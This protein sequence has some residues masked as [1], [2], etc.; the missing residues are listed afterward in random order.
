MS[1]NIAA[2]K[3]VNARRWAAMHVNPA[4]IPALDRVA[5][6]L[7]AP[8]AMA[9]YQA[10]SASTKVP[11]WVIAVI[12]ERESSQNWKDSLAQGDP[13]N[14]VSTHVP[15]GRGPFTSWEQAAVDA[16]ENAAPYAAR[17]TDWSAGGTLTLLEEYNGLGYAKRG[18][19]SPY[20]WASTN[21]YVK[22]KYVADGRFDPNAV[23]RQQGCAALLARMAIK[24][25]S[26]MLFTPV[27]ATNNPH[28]PVAAPVAPTPVVK[29]PVRFQGFCIRGLLSVFLSRAMENL[30]AEIN[31]RYPG[32]MQV[33]DHGYW[34]SYFSNV[35]WLTQQARSIHLNNKRVVLIG[36]SFGA[37]AAIMAANSLNMQD[38]PVD[39]LCPIDPAAQYSTAVPPNVKRVVAFY[40]TTPGDLGE[41]V[42]HA[43]P[44]WV[45][46]NWTARSVEYHRV[47]GHLAIANDPFVHA[48]ILEAI[49]ELT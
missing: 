14:R 29:T 7:V 35:G 25:P 47:E 46:A 49:K 8:V 36:H 21:Q 32:T 20:V 6:Q 48:K 38:I 10:V 4:A 17:N 18:M 5:A 42:V 31:A 27:V 23:D 30:T 11:W 41:G 28:P 22:G 3:E 39:L 9:H 37:T 45:K 26:I 43:G 40:Q 44:G 33:S 1:A 12:H 13:W 34:F 2:L 19:P 24:D 16:L 15:R